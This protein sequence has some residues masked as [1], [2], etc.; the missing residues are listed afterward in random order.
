MGY[1]AAAMERDARGAR[2]SPL[3]SFCAFCS[4]FLSVSSFLFFCCFVLD[5]VCSSGETHLSPLWRE[6]TLPHCVEIG[7]FTRRVTWGT[8]KCWKA[9]GP[10]QTTKSQLGENFTAEP[11]P[12]RRIDKGFP[13]DDDAAVNQACMR[14]PQCVTEATSDKR[15]RSKKC[16]PC[17]RGAERLAALVRKGGE[18]S[19]RARKTAGA[20]R[21]PLDAVL[22]RIQGTVAGATDVG[23]NLPKSRV[24][25]RTWGKEP[26]GIDGLPFRQRPGPRLAELQSVGLFLQ[27]VRL[28]PLK[29]KTKS[30]KIRESSG[31]NP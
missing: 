27:T 18:A 30:P 1:E 2:I 11:L 28:L 4:G 17:P 7:Q 10:R 31:R 21:D 13:L 14:P 19:G 16:I 12:K 15:R 9:G 23:H 8:T 25:G 26:P 3:R 20:R 29:L 6:N 5:L 22:A 24:Q